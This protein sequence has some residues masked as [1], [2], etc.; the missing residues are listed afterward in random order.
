MK[1]VINNLVTMAHV[2]DVQRSADFY[3]QMGFRIGRFQE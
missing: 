1:P 2:A 3:S